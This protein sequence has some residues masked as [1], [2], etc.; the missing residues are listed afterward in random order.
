MV[1]FLSCIVLLFILTGCQS[2]DFGSNNDHLLT[3]SN[4]SDNDIFRIKKGSIICTKD[5]EDCKGVIDDGYYLSNN[6]MKNIIKIKSG[7]LTAKND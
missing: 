6:Y 1:I 2:L 5:N 7:L 4:V 3:I